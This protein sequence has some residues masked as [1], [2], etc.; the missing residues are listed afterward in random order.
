MSYVNFRPKLESVFRDRF[1]NTVASI[2]ENT[3]S[4]KLEEMVFDEVNW[5]ENES[6]G[7]ISQRRKYRAL[8]LFFRDLIR[9]QWKPLFVN[10]N[11][12]MFAPNVDNLQNATPS[13][14]KDYLKTWMKTSRFERL[15]SFSSFIN[16]TEKN[17]I[18]KLIADGEYLYQ[19]VQELRSG[20]NINSCINP[21]LQLV[22]ENTKDQFTGIRL[23]DVWRYFRLTWATPSETTPGRTMLYLIRDAAHPYHAVMGIASLENSAVQIT[24]RD[25][26]LGW[27]A[28]SYIAKMTASNSP[29]FIHKC[30]KDLMKY[31]DEGISGIY[32]ADIATQKEVD[33]VSDELIEK[34]MDI[35]K[36]ASKN[37]IELLMNENSSEEERSDLGRISVGVENSLYLKKRAEQLAKYLT[38]KKYLINFLNLDGGNYLEKWIKFSPTDECKAVVRNALLA[39][40]SQHIGT[41]M[42]ELNVCGAVHPYNE[43]LSGKL[44]ALLALSPQMVFDYNQR[45][46]DKK[47]EIASRLKKEDV[48]RPANLVYVG[49]TSLY[50]VGSSQYN[51]LK[52]DKSVFNKDYQLQWKEVGTTEGFGSMHISRATTRCLQEVNNEQYNKINNVFGEGTSPKLRL[53][54]SSIHELLDVTQDE[55]SM[56]SKH[57]MKRIIFAGSLISNIE[58]YF[59]GFD[60]KPNYIYDIKEYKKD[61]QK[62]IDFWRNRWLMS[63]IK[64]EPAIERIRSFNK[65]D[66]LVSQEIKGASIWEFKPLL[67]DTDMDEGRNT[68]KQIDF[69]RNLYLGSSAYADKQDVAILNKIHIKTSLDETILEWLEKGKSVILTGNAGDGKTHILRIL[70][71]RIKNINEFITV[72]LDASQKTEEEIFEEWKCCYENKTPICL[73]INAAV[74]RSLYLNHKDFDPVV[75]AYNQMMNGLITVEEEPQ[76]P[77]FVIVFDLSR[78]NVLEEEIF[79]ETIERLISPE[80]YLECKKCRKHKSCDVIRNIKLLKSKMFRERLFEIF[81]RIHLQGYHATLRELL[82]FFSF[83]IFGN[84]DCDKLDKTSESDEYNITNLIYSGKGKI[85]DQVRNAFDPV[86]ISHPHIDEYIIDNSMESSGW[87]KAF[88]ELN[89]G[90]DVENS[91]RFKLNKRLFYFFHKDGKELINISDDFVSQFKKLLDEDEKAQ[92][93]DLFSKINKFYSLN[94]SSNRAITSWQG[95][96]YD[97]SVRKILISFS[98]DEFER[99]SFE[100]I[101]PKLSDIMASGIEYTT[102]Y[103]LLVSKNNKDA[104]LKIDFEFY[105]MLLQV[106]SGIPM[107]FM[108]NDMV[109]RLWTFS[110]KLKNDEDYTDNHEVD[111]LT[112]NVNAKTKTSVKIDLDDDKFIEIRKVVD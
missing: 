88:G 10:G 91:E 37:R 96:R 112:L 46:S 97:Y 3:S 25:E 73:A 62:I 60:T 98:D 81:N 110:E 87:D 56:L 79:N 109:K 44:V 111:L 76:N 90:V 38:A 18:E 27:N 7:N 43:L 77:E 104:R 78:R 103:L 52:I 92:I 86:K 32:Y 85:F 58:D 41:S 21:Y 48:I 102:N 6:T 69:V 106:E 31:L 72:E 84:R 45:Y 105:C 108:E 4:D 82:S 75:E 24:K 22:D 59:L 74:L 28:Y 89:E 51:R 55:L 94:S 93:K 15:V 30:I 95:L 64:Y 107:L 71:N 83:L 20:A 23:G 65:N 5:A 26:F 29:D 42:M 67:E 47:S 17:G 33:N 36:T 34:L 101:R 50:S 9:A 8:W 19:K 70:E 49:T 39:R 1:Y 68:D 35:A 2:T 57:A 100:I 61:T 80:I 40:K 12:E 54:V 13:E 16:T 14:K 11:L 66:Y 53:I 99:S 63:R